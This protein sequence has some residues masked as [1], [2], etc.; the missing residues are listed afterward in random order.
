MSLRKLFAGALLAAGFA[1]LPQGAVNAADDEASDAEWSVVQMYM[2]RN[3]RRHARGRALVA[4]EAGRGAAFRCEK[5]K[6]FVFIATEKVN[7]RRLLERGSL[8]SARTED[9][10]LTIADGEPQDDVWVG[11][12][13]GKVYLARKKSTTSA[14]FRA[15]ATDKPVTF[16]KQGEEALSIDVPDADESVFDHFLEQCELDPGNHPYG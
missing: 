6:L 8:Q 12:Y 13:G 15:L 9:M 3:G 10:V 11:M 7:M 4:D 16:G 2:V 1:A 14:L 5:G